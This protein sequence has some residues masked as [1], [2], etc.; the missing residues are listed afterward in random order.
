MY[1]R[2]SAENQRVV[3]GCSMEQPYFSRFCNTPPREATGSDDG[4]LFGPIYEFGDVG[5]GEAG[6]GVGAAVVH[7]QTSC[8]G[9]VEGGAGE[10][11]VGH[12]AGELVD[13]AGR[14]QI[15]AAAGKH[16]PGL[17]EVEQGR[18]EGVDVAVAGAEHAVV[19]Q[20]PA[21]GGL[22]GY[23]A[24]ADFHALPGG[25]FEG[26][27]SHHVAVASPE[28]EVGRLTVE[29]VTEGGVSGVAGAREHGVVAVDLAGE[30][31]AVAVVGEEGV[32]KLVERFEVGGPGYADCGAVVAVAPGDDEA[33]ADLG[34][35][36][37]VAVDPF[38]HFGVGALKADVF[39]VDVP[40][41]A[42]DGE[43]GMDAHAAVGV[44]AAEHS[45]E[46][47]FSF[48]EGHYG[49]VE[50]TVGCRQ[51]VAGNHGVLRVAPHY[52]LA[53]LGAV[54]PGYFGKRLSDDFEMFH[55]FVKKGVV[56]LGFYIS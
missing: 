31:H 17:L 19:E 15:W 38:A 37:V 3:F 29:Y 11:D 40:F 5:E 53:A 56:Y 27:G 1:A 45:G 34:H 18:A 20:Q 55:V 22:D 54:L 42:V 16:L 2:A 36:G 44:V 39:F 49:R 48:L 23:G 8:L 12:V 13:F 14:N 47:V 51:G 30:H 10:G 7:G 50:Y 32:L 46:V 43:T 6:H 24:G 26:R 9:V 52:F 21:F 35:A 4:V 41:E 28:L 25:E 33:V